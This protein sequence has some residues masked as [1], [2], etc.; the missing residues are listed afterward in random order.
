[1]FSGLCNWLDGW[2]PALWS[3]AVFGVPIGCEGVDPTKTR[4]KPQPPIPGHSRMMQ[5][6][7][8]F[9][10][11]NLVAAQCKSHL[12]QKV[13]EYERAHTNSHSTRAVDT[14][15]RTNELHTQWTSK[16]HRPQHPSYA[17]SSGT[18]I[19]SYSSVFWIYFNPLWFTA[20]HMV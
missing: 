17:R 15:S 20:T 4:P 3:E 10:Y 9:Q 12:I 13:S 19:R 6:I 8:G 5:R 2:S 11:N 1:M 16:N 7:Q 14:E 18:P